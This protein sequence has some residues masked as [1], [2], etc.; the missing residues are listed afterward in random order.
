MSEKS[1]GEALEQAEINNLL[2]SVDAATILRLQPGDTLAIKVSASWKPEQYRH[3]EKVLKNAFPGGT[4]FFLYPDGSIVDFK[5][6]RTV[7]AGD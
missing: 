2:A 5:I 1:L 3:A 6:I 7:E 4:N